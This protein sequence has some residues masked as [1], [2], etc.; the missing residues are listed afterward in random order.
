M[1]TTGFSG[2]SGREFRLPPVPQTPAFAAV[3]VPQVG[4]DGIGRSTM[5]L[6]S[7]GLMWFLLHL[8]VYA[9]HQPREQWSGQPISLY[10]W[11]GLIFGQMA[12]VL[13]WPNQRGL[14]GWCHHLFALLLITGGSWLFSDILTG[15][16]TQWW[17]GLVVLVLGCKLAWWA[18]ER[19]TSIRSRYDRKPGSFS[20]AQ[21]LVFSLWLTVVTSLSMAIQEDWTL[22]ATMLACFGGLSLFLAIQRFAFQQLF[23]P[24]NDHWPTPQDNRAWHILDRVGIGAI[25]LVIQA[26][27]ACGLWQYY[28]A[29]P[30]AVLVF[31][32][33]SVASGWQAIDLWFARVV[34]LNRQPLPQP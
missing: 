18:L 3:S 34:Q 11:I 24:S 23:W 19:P 4:W 27:V 6:G 5:L 1:N 28:D 14:A 20:L 17:I 31:C 8:C 22:S 32:L 26:G 13:M 30:Q 12:S 2:R 7:Y 33:C 16:A 10:V 29:E 21:W 9:Y 15:P 25:I